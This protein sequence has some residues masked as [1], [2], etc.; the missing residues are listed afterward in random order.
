MWQW[1]N[2]WMK[3]MREKRL[4]RPTHMW[5]SRHRLSTWWLDAE[6]RRNDLQMINIQKQLMETNCLT[7]VFANH[8]W[9]FCMKENGIE[10]LVVLAV[11]KLAKHVLSKVILASQKSYSKKNRSTKQCR[12][13]LYS[14][15]ATNPPPYCS[16]IRTFEGVSFLPTISSSSGDKRSGAT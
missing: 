3:P 9:R 15:C 2:L 16:G 7:K 6:S 12:W 14:S 5:L 10:L 1:V 11:G 13:W 8:L 4:T